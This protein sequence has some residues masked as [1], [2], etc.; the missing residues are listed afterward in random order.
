MHN[1]SSWNFRGTSGSKEEETKVIVAVSA[2]SDSFIAQRAAR[3][4]NLGTAQEIQC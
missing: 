2:N 3:I 4:N 1:C